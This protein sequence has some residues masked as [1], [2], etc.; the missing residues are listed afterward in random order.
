MS[1]QRTPT[2]RRAAKLLGIHPRDIVRLVRVAMRPYPTV[3]VHTG[4]AIDIRRV[5]PREESYSQC[6]A[7]WSASAR[8]PNLVQTGRLTVVWRG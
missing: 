4:P 3:H 2:K 7:S 8:P 1:L 5:F 6:S